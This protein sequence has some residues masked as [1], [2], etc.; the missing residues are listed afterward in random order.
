MLVECPLI[1]EVEPNRLTD[2]YS[3]QKQT[4]K[5]KFWLI[6]KHII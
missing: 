3:N 6:Q 1:Y 5:S 2:V 4:L